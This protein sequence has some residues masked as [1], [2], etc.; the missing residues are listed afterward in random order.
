MA[1]KPAGLPDHIRHYINGELFDSISGDTFDVLEP[2]TNETYI[3]C[4]S[5]DKA[6]ADAAVAAAKAAFD[7]GSWANMLPRQRAQILQAMFHGAMMPSGPLLEN[8]C[9]FIIHQLTDADIKLS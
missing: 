9:Y 1:N 5:G 4:A 6:D 3:Q 7:E 2:T 8:D